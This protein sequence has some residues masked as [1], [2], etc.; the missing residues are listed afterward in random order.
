M[1]DKQKLADEAAATAAAEG[2]SPEEIEQI[3]KTILES[4]PNPAHDPLK[5]ELDKVKSKGQGKTELEKA[6]YARQQIDKRISALEGDEGIHA[7]EDEDDDKPVTVGMLKEKAKETAQKTALDLIEQQIP[8]ETEKELTKYHLQN[9]IKSTGNPTEDIRLARAIV[10][11]LKNNQIIE[12]V[13]RTKEAKQ[14]SSGSGAPAKKDDDV[15][16]PTAEETAFMKA[17]FN[18]TKEAILAARKKE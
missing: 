15:F 1:D 17:P 7:D 4:D 10:N 13:Q 11:D 2:K 12:E 3:K 14:H 5:Q 8:D 6:R 9:T 16:V 18:L